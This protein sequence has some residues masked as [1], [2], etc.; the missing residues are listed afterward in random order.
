MKNERKLKNAKQ[1]ED[2]RARSMPIQK[3]E[4]M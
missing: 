1:K 2:R 4:R 3:F